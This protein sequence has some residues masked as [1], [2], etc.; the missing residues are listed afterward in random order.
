MARLL[1]VDRIIGVYL[2]TEFRGL[3]FF[4]NFH[5]F[6]A[7]RRF[8]L[9]HF[10]PQAQHI[11]MSKKLGFLFCTC[12]SAYIWLLSRMEILFFGRNKLFSRHSC[13]RCFYLI[14]GTFLRKMHTS[15]MPWCFVEMLT[16]HEIDDTHW[17]FRVQVFCCNEAMHLGNI[18]VRGC[19]TQIKW[20]MH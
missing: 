9:L 4:K 2:K 12:R 3:H 5:N 18:C 6:T 7:V 16:C 11:L 17:W 10:V 19:T 20:S 13:S 14:V 8:I 15:S 1:Q